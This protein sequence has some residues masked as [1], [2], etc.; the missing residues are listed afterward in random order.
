VA[1]R[2]TQSVD[3]TAQSVATLRGELFR[4][5]AAIVIDIRFIE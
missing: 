1:R 2:P 5:D 3:E 4:V